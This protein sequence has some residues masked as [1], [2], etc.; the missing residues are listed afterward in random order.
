MRTVLITINYNDYDTTKDFLDK[1]K[2]YKILDRII[3]VD[4]HSTDDSYKQLKKYENSKI[5]VLKAKKNGGY[6]YGNNLGIKYVKE[7]FDECNIVISNP[8][9]IV[10][11]E[12]LKKLINDLEQNEE[13]AIV[14]PIINTHGKLEKGWKLSTGFQEVLLSIPVF[15]T[16]NR[17]RIIGYKNSYFKKGLNQVDVVSGCFFLSRLSIFEKIN[18]YDEKIFLYYEENVISQKLKQKNYKI[19]LDTNCQIIHNHSVSIDKANS[20]KA[21]YKILKDS[22]IYYMENYAYSSKISILLVK[23]IKYIGLKIKK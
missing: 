20:S 10:E 5:C 19:M 13:Y 12:T 7:K 6:G 2:S 3:V 21:K 17:H 11:E 1:I 14:A 23:F 8:D 18:Y 4:N 9:I 22:Q 16:K 15:G